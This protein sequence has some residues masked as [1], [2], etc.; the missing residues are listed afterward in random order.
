M[1]AQL[2]P[3]DAS[4]SRRSA[5]DS[6]ECKTQPRNAGTRKSIS[7]YFKDAAGVILSR[8]NVGQ[9]P[10]RGHQLARLDSLELIRIILRVP[11]SKHRV[12]FNHRADEPFR[13]ICLWASPQITPCS[14]PAACNHEPRQVTPKVL[15]GP[16]AS[17]SC[18][19][20]AEKARPRNSPCEL[21]Y[22]LANCYMPR[23]Y[24]VGMMNLLG[25]GEGYLLKVKY[26]VKD[27]RECTRQ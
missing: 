14:R 11:A 8:S 16:H 22:G 7:K 18:I 3:S 24:N 15:F 23:G 9:Q 4:V 5:R 12:K 1:P 20:P 13:Q 10:R 2:L 26:L 27:S 25:L 6:G 17:D 19:L 21:Q